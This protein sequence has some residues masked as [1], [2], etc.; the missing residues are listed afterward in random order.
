[1]KRGDH[2][3]VGSRGRCA[4]QPRRRYADSALG[5]ESV[6]SAGCHSESMADDYASSDNESS[7]LCEA[8]GDFVPVFVRKRTASTQAL[9]GFGIDFAVDVGEDSSQETSPSDDDDGDNS[10]SNGIGLDAAS[11]GLLPNVF[12]S[13]ES[14]DGLGYSLARDGRERGIGGGVGDYYGHA[15]AHRD[16]SVDARSAL[17]TS[18]V[19]GDG[20]LSTSD[21]LTLVPSDLHINRRLLYAPSVD[22]MG[23]DGEGLRASAADYIMP[24]L[25]QLV[26]A[27]AS[28]PKGASVFW[29]RKHGFEW[30]WDPLFVVHWVVSISLV[31]C[32]SGAL[33]LYLHTSDF[34]SA[35]GWLVVLAFETLL[36]TVALLLDIVIV[37]RDTEAPEVKA[38]RAVGR[39]RDYAFERGTPTV[40]AA[41]G[42][43]RV[44]NVVV[45]SGTR[46]CKLCNKCVAGYDH[47][48]RW[49]NTCIGDRNYRVFVA[50]VAIAL[51]HTALVLGCSIRVACVAGSDLLQFRALVWKAVGAPLSLP[52]SATWIMALAGTAFV[53]LGA[54]ILAALTAFLGLA[55]L[56]GFHFRLWLCSMRTV[57]YLVRPRRS[58]GTASSWLHGGGRY[59]TISS[60]SPSDSTPSERFQRARSPSASSL[61]SGHFGTASAVPA[62]ATIKRI[63]CLPAEGVSLIV[64]SGE[65]VVVLS[66]RSP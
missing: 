41:T 50:F 33:L 15:Y 28:V 62:S 8:G 36:A 3:T 30:P 21:S 4:H 12:A 61:H 9:R 40:D 18:K 49:L 53:V 64:G 10:S 57:D 24:R 54:Y 22:A 23:F 20:T 42:Q 19:S 65:S 6:L 1:M 29:L 59:R 60:A 63:A 13:E 37:F 66:P 14:L 2:S 32:F 34:G 5:V 47:H 39:N 51:V 16:G 45:R 35:S 25:A 17:A 31:V 55:L 52:Q 7:A 11:R 44:C 46:H 43:C 38:A 56:L 26:P 58:R 27:A 48:C